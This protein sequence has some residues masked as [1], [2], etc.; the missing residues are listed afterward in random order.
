MESPENMVPISMSG[1]QSEENKVSFSGIDH[2][3]I[4]VKDIEAG[5]ETWRDKFGLT[6][7]HRVE[8][9]ESGIWQAFFSLDD[10]SFLELLAPIH[11]ESAISERLNTQGEGIHVVALEVDQ[12]EES[13]AEMQKQDVKL[14]GVGTQQVLV[15]PRSANGVMLQLWSKDRPH[16]WREELSEQDMEESREENDDL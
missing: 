1:K 9:K 11:N 12:L 7:T 13:V 6:L 3:V 14:L 16:M 2:I 15:H 4:L 5:I 8:L 10:G